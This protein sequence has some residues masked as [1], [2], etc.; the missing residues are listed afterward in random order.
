MILL[1]PLSLN[2]SSILDL[3]DFLRGYESLK[4]I[5]FNVNL[6]DYFNN[7]KCDYRDQDSFEIFPNIDIKIKS[8]VWPKIDGFWPYMN[9]LNADI[10]S[11]PY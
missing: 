7:L 3:V 11:L 10:Q 4:K 8:Y 9:H 6:D 1:L 2:R 5:T